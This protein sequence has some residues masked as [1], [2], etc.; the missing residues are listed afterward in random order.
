MKW[1]EL[2][3]LILGRVE[4]RSSDLLDFQIIL[5]HAF[6]P[7]KKKKSVVIV[8]VIEVEM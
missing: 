6:F 2:G 4:A 3:I 7:L 1:Y 5:A 8:V